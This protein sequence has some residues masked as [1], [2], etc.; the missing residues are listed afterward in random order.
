MHTLLLVSRD[1]AYTPQVHLSCADARFS[2][3]GIA[4]G[5]SAA[6]PLALHPVD[7]SHYGNI[8]QVDGEGP[9]KT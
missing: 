3:V 4:V 1:P 5:Y 2:S 8:L 9:P 6:S 7:L